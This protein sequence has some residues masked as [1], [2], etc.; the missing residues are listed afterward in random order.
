[1]S[2]CIIFNPGSR[3][4][5]SGRQL[6]RLESLLKANGMDYTLKTTAALEDARRFSEEANR[7]GCPV[8]V[9]VGGDGTINQVL[10]GFY[11]EDGTRISTAKLGVVY[12]GTSPDFCRS[13]HIPLDLEQAVAVLKAGRSRPVTLGRIGLHTEPKSQGDSVYFNPGD[14]KTAIRYFACCANIGLGPQLA[15]YANSGIRKY[16]GDTLG[17]FLSLLRCVFSYKPGTLLVMQDGREAVYEAVTNL[18]IGRTHFIASGIQVKN[19]LVLDDRRFYLLVVQHLKLSKLGAVLKAIY[20]GETITP[21]DQLLMDYCE[22]IEI[23]GDANVRVEFD[24]DPAGYLPC[25]I[26]PAKDPLDVICKC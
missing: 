5:K 14:E 25:T 18:S 26:A 8:V 11:N 17:T 13:F 1:M 9:A 3:G 10:N 21:T 20:S 24:G 12:T 22:S 19:D 2:C 4:G 6:A 15:H 23:K 7:S 16:M